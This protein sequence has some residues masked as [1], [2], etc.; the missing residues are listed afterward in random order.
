MF[1]TAL[2]PTSRVIPPSPLYRSLVRLFVLCVAMFLATCNVYGF[3]SPTKRT[4]EIT[5]G[6]HVPVLGTQVINA[7]L[8]SNTLYLPIVEIFNILDINVNASLDRC[9]ITGFVV[10]EQ[11]TYA[12]D[13]NKRTLIYQGRTYTLGEEDFMLTTQDLF[14]RRDLYS[15]IFGL[16]YDFNYRGLEISLTTNEPIPAVQ[17]ILRERAARSIH[18]YDDDFV[19]DTAINVDRTALDGAVIDWNILS[20]TNPK[21]EVANYSVGIGGEFLYGELQAV[22][23]AYGKAPIHLKDVPA[24]WRM[25]FPNDTRIQSVALLNNQALSTTPQLPA[26]SGFQLSNSPVVPR[27]SYGYY[28]LQE[29]TEPDWSVE[30]Y[31]NEQLIGVT[32]ADALGFYEFEIPLLYGYTNVRLKH[33]GPYGQERIVDQQLQVPFTFVPE[34]TA[35]YTIAGGVLIDR[36]NDRILGGEVAYGWTKDITVG[37]GAYYIEDDLQKPWAPLATTSFRLHPNVM[38]SGKYVHDV[39]SRVVANYFDKTGFRL[40]AAWARFPNMTRFFPRSLKEER[41]LSFGTPLISTSVPISFR[42]S[43]AQGINPFDDEYNAQA[44]ATAYLWR[45]PLTY[46]ANFRL[47]GKLNDLK[48]SHGTSEMYTLLQPGLRFLLRP[49]A[50][51][52]H[53]T[54]R[55]RDLRLGLERP[56]TEGIFTNAPLWVSAVYQY[57]VPTKQ[58]AAYLNVRL[59]L[60]FMQLSS[61]YSH[62]PS[63][64]R[65]RQGARSSIVIDTR[66]PDVFMHNRNLLG[67]GAVVFRPYLDLNNDL[68]RDENEPPVRDL[69]IGINRG[70]VYPSA[71]GTEVYVYDLDPYRTLMVQ[72]SGEGFENVAWQPYWKNIALTPEANRFKP[73][74]LPI[75]IGGEV[76]GRVTRVVEGRTIGVGGVKVL[77]RRQ[78]DNKTYTVITS[79]DGEYDFLGLPPGMYTATVDPAQL[80]KAR[81][82]T[83]P[84]GR[85]FEVCVVSE[86]DYVQGIDFDLRLP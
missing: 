5:V 60:S 41:K 10:Q 51:F 44:G 6:M 21:F 57:Q 75:Y 52:D 24:R 76:T 64:D 30:L 48:R 37:G 12:I 71:D 15:S 53:E 26:A 83:D 77:F 86:G 7:I 85:P 17:K 69:D 20:S 66:T 31:V 38:V 11:R 50:V 62:D 32:R 22:L 8:D 1:Y 61:M 3:G 58:S 78:T 34:G 54:A 35:E 40:E 73:V 19:P 39:E 84:A 16:V 63:G 45:T 55:F 33:Y 42:G 28:T 59:D 56:I 70:I 81:A 4:E 82:T 79:S 29:Y 13:A 47:T 68:R 14:L 36:G 65:F 72:P 46:F 27:R 9:A 2:I 43:I 74:D 49:H 23:N 67:R 25:V 80:V 18:R